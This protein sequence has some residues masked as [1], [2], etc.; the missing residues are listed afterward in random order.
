MIT[1]TVSLDLKPL[2]DLCRNAIK[3]AERAVKPMATQMVN[4]VKNNAPILS[5]ALRESITAK[6]ETKGTT[7]LAIIGPDLGYLMAYAGNIVKTPYEY[8]AKEDALMQFLSANTP[9]ADELANC[10]AEE[11]QK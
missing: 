6:F 10:M 5:G 8:A 7:A 4:E 9:K 2:Q 1:A 11:F 3:R